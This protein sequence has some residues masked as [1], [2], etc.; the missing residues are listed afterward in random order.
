M[1]KTYLEMEYNHPNANN[2]I[3]IRLQFVYQLKVT[4]LGI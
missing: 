4:L 2:Q 1:T 3:K